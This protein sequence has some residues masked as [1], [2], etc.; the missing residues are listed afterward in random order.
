MQHQNSINYK[1]YA[2]NNDIVDDNNSIV[3]QVRVDAQGKAIVRRSP[4]RAS[5]SNQNIADG[6]GDHHRD[7]SFDNG[8]EDGEHEGRFDRNN[9]DTPAGM[10]DICIIRN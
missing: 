4:A 6:T 9:I 3:L 5:S 8:M 10:L 2:D 1:Y 7:T